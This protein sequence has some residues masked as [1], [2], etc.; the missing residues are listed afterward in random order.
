M[1]LHWPYLSSTLLQRLDEERMLTKRALT[2]EE[3]LRV[4]LIEIEA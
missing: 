1:P 3:E 2:L 4:Q